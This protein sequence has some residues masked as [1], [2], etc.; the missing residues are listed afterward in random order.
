M[1]RNGGLRDGTEPGSFAAAAGRPRT[2][3]VGGPGNSLARCVPVWKRIQRRNHFLVP[4]PRA[5]MTGRTLRR[6]SKVSCPGAACVGRPGMQSVF[7][8]VSRSVFLHKGDGYDFRY[9]T[10]CGSDRWD[11]QALG[12]RKKP[13]RGPVGGHDRHRSLRRVFELEPEKYGRCGPGSPLKTDSAPFM[14]GRGVHSRKNPLALCLPP[15][16]IGSPFPDSGLTL[17]T[18]MIHESKGICFHGV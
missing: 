8:A 6:R 2:R 5:E 18:A 3:A 11:E 16:T 9:G 17:E 4:S 7:L 1:V 14:G 12:E 15:V 10:G 13:R